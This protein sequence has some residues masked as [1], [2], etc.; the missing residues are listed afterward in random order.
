MLSALTLKL[1]KRTL[2]KARAYAKRN[3]TTIDALVEAYLKTLI[4]KPAS[5]AEELSP[6]VRELCGVIKLDPDFDWKKAR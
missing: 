5:K 2:A 3:D 6:L 1:D 4:D